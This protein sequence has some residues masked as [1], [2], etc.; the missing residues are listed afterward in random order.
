M[1]K[2]SPTLFTV[3]KNTSI[4]TNMRRICMTGEAMKQYPKNTV[5]G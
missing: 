1:A 4:S 5:G 2:P 3:T